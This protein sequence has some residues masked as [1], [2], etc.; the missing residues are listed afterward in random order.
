MA[1]CNPNTLLA[2]GA[3]YQCLDEDQFQ[4]AVLQLLCD[5]A[6]SGGG[7]GGSA[8]LLQ[9]DG[10]PVDD[11]T[12]PFAPALYTDLLTGVI[13]TWNANTGIWF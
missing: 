12:N 8:Q 9:G 13:Y 11:P 7:G 6:A 1:T 10:A 4:M 2:S 3:C 5:I